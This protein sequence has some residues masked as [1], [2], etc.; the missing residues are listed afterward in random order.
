M[1]VFYLYWTCECLVVGEIL[2]VS[3]LWACSFERNKP[4]TT[5]SAISF[6]SPLFTCMPVCTWYIRSISAPKGFT[7][8]QAERVGLL[9]RIDWMDESRNTETLRACNWLG[10]V[11]FQTDS[12]RSYSRD[13]FNCFNTSWKLCFFVWMSLFLVMNGIWRW[14]LSIYWKNEL[15]RY[16]NIELKY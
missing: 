14:L 9:S 10:Q 6:S 12:T 11:G 15:Y 7:K 3:L 2:T 8:T 16:V 4:V 5:E 1:S 13:F